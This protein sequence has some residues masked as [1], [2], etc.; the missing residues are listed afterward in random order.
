MILTVEAAEIAAAKENRA[1]ATRPGKGRFFAEM[2]ED[3]GNGGLR[4]C[5]AISPFTGGSLYSAC[6]GGKACTEMTVSPPLWP[7]EGFHHVSIKG[8]Y[9][10]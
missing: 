9:F 2:G 10:S 1:R 5:S 8:T 7:L 6:R 3:R 4:T